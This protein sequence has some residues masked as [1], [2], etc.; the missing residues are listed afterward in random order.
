MLGQYWLVVSLVPAAYSRT[1]MISQAMVGSQ[2]TSSSSAGAQSLVGRWRNLVR[3]C[4]ILRNGTQKLPC[5]QRWGDGESERVRGTR[6]RKLW[7]LL[8]ASRWLGAQTEGHSIGDR[9]KQEALWHTP[10]RR[11]PPRT[12][13]Q[14]VVPLRHPRTS[15]RLPVLGAW[16]R[17]AL[18][19]MRC[20]QRTAASIGCAG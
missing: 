8:C 3:K 2:G 12:Q 19:A 18:L 4:S 11:G 16:G 13:R 9:P 20:S 10:Q 7:A 1:G 14:I 15:L 6:Q 17:N 5:R